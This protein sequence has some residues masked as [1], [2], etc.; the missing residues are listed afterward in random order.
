M[1][2]QVNMQRVVEIATDSGFEIDLAVK[3]LDETFRTNL[4][5]RSGE[6]SSGLWMLDIQL[7][8]FSRSLG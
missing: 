8:I 7:Y 5:R 2:L 4:C 3:Y 1:V 6:E